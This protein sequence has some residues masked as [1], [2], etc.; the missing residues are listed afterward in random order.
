MPSITS[1]QST[2]T[3]TSNIYG[4]VSNT[5]TL[6]KI[7]KSWPRTTPTTTNYY[8]SSH[9]IT[10][11]DNQS[12]DGPSTLIIVFAV[13]GGL[14]ALVLLTMCAAQLLKRARKRNVDGH[15]DLSKDDAVQLEKFGHA[16][17]VN[18]PV[19]TYLPVPKQK[20]F[21]SLRPED[22]NEQQAVKLGDYASA[23]DLY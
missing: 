6:Q 10:P 1:T 12:S 8:Q 13:L 3:P 17:Q 2:T 11:T 15:T 21:V 18:K 22:G 14:V 20:L 4:T 9:Y 19:G 5:P 23:A 16:A 7:T